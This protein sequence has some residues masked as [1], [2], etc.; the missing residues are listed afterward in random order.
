MIHVCTANCYCP[1]CGK[2]LVSKPYEI[3]GE[4]EYAMFMGC[5][6]GHYKIKV[7]SVTYARTGQGGGE[8]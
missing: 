2:H 1:E 4:N 8:S 3:L 6:D 5:P 7:G